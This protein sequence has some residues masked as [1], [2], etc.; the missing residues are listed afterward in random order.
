MD[1]KTGNSEYLFNVNALLA[2]LFAEPPS[3]VW[4]F[5]AV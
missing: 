4:S 3:N 2:L 5:E 1:G